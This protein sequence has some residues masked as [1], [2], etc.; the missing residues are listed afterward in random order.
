MKGTVYRE[1]D[2]VAPAS[3]ARARGVF[4]SDDMTV[5]ACTWRL[6]SFLCSEVY[7]RGSSKYLELVGE[8]VQG[9]VIFCDVDRVYAREMRFC[10]CGSNIFKL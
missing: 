3:T 7:R 6:M 9:N 1:A 4:C 8:N 5:R 10:R 2:P